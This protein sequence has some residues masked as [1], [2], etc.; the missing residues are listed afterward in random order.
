[1]KMPFLALHS[2]KYVYP[3]AA[4]IVVENFKR[5]TTGIK[6]HA[7]IFVVLALHRAVVTGVPKRMVNIRRAHSVLKRHK[8]N[9]ISGSMRLVYTPIHFLSIK[10]AAF[11]LRSEL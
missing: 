8:V 5:I 6:A 2:V 1:M 4:H 7:Q 11:T 10:K 3:I 9:V